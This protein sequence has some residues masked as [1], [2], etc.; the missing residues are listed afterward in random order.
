[1]VIVVSYST[2]LTKHDEIGSNSPEGFLR[3]RTTT[4]GDMLADNYYLDREKMSLIL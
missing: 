3:W 4:A 2:N 1:M